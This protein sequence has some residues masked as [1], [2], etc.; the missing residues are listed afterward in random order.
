[1]RLST[2]WILF[3]VLALLG[4]WGLFAAYHMAWRPLGL[5]AMLLR[6]Q[7]MVYEPG[8]TVIVGDSLLAALPHSGCV[9][10]MAVPGMRAAEL[11]PDPVASRAPSR[12]IV[13]IGINDLW[14]GATPSAIA[15]SIG[16]FVRA[17]RE[18]VPQANIM[19]LSL[20]P[21]ADGEFGKVT[22]ADI[23]ETNAAIRTTVLALGARHADLSGMFGG[24]QLAP[25][26]TYDGLHLNAAGIGVLANALFQGLAH[27]TDAPL[28]P[29]A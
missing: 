13:K 24:D 8:P 29:R 18:R 16:Q 4:S 14:F 22:N 1:M 23:R 2:A 19:V 10:N 9:A 6:L 20:L 26:L 3:L 12:V 21:I 5:H 15:N 17:L 11:D 28:C 25:A 7:S 27:K